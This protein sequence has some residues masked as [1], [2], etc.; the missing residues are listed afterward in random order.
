LHL[1]VISVHRLLHDLSGY[2]IIP[3]W[4]EQPRPCSCK[5]A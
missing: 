1:H 5:V 2:N 4:W 3:C